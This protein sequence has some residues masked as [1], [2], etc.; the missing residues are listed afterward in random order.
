MKIADQAIMI[1]VAYNLAD[2]MLE[3]RK[4]KDNA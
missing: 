3:A 4:E 2:L 1:K